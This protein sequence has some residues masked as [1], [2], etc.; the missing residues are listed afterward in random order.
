MQKPRPLELDL[1][2]VHLANEL[3]IAELWQVFRED[4]FENYEQLIEE[5]P[6]EILA[7][8]LSLFTQKLVLSAALPEQYERTLAQF[9]RMLEKNVQPSIQTVAFAQRHL[10]SDAIEILNEHI[11]T[12]L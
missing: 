1:I 6:S 9:K 4:S 8:I 3:Q 5:T 2:Q 12:T 7:T 11:S 10:Q